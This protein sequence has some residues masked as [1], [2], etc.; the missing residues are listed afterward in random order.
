VNYRGSS[1]R[2]EAFSKAIYADWGNKE[3]VDL[4]GAVDAAVA[5][6]YADPDRMVLGGWSYGGFLTDATIAPDTRF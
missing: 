2:G 3:V 4:L 6:G 5:A 1:G